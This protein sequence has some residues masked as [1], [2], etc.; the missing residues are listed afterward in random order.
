[1]FH[2]DIFTNQHWELNSAGDIDKLREDATSRRKRDTKSL[3]R[4]KRQA[5]FD[6]DDVDALEPSVEEELASLSDEEL[7]ALAS[8]VRNE[9]DAYESAVLGEK[10]GSAVYDDN[11]I[12]DVESAPE[13]QT[14]RLVPVVIEDYANYD[15]STADD[16][17]LFGRPRRSDPDP[18]YAV[19]IPSASEVAD[20][21]S[22]QL[23][24]QTAEGEANAVDDE[25]DELEL[26]SRIAELAEILNERVASGY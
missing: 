5:V 11:D 19:F 25:L 20:D 23:F 21:D 13:Q 17:P 18:D 10:D 1:M 4:S 24:P 8:I 9:L 7:N 14:T 12:Y 3:G 26:R 22:A 2:R 6:Y 15:Q 16:E